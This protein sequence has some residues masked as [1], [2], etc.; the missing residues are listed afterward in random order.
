MHRGDLRGPGIK[1]TPEVELKLPK[2]NMSPN[3]N[4]D[5][6]RE[7]RVCAQPLTNQRVTSKLCKHKGDP[8][9]ARP[10]K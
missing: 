1:V 2:L 10:P 3:S 5:P 7:Y 9:E 8:K 4:T 6:S